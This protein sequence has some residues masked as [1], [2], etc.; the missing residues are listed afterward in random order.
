MQPLIKFYCLISLLLLITTIAF[1]KEPLPDLTPIIINAEQGLVEVKNLGNVAA[2]PS[3]L[4]V[5]CSTFLKVSKSSPCASG[6]HLSGYIKKWN[7]LPFN[8]P[9]LKPGASYQIHLFSADAF[10]RKIG[11]YGMKITADPLK[12]ITESNE[13]NNYTRL[14]TTIK[15][16]PGKLR[17]VVQDDSKHALKSFD[18][19]IQKHGSKKNYQGIVVSGNDKTSPLE[20]KI[21]EGRYDVHIVS[22][23]YFYAGFNGLNK[24]YSHVADIQA[25]MD[26]HILAP[27]REKIIS[28]TLIKSRKT[29]DKRV[30]FKRL[31]VGFLKINVNTDSKHESKFW[32][33]IKPSGQRH[34][35]IELYRPFY[36]DSTLKV[37]LAAG[38][39]L[40]QIEPQNGSYQGPGYKRND[41]R[42]TIKPGETLQ[43]K[44]TFTRQIKGK[45]KLTVLLN[46]N[47]SKAKI[48]ILKAGGKGRF[49]ATRAS[50][51]MITNRVELLPGHYD[52]SVVPLEY[53]L[54]LGGVDVFHGGVEGPSVKTKRIP[55][56]KP[57]IL[58]N[59]E[60]KPG[61]SLEKTLNFKKNK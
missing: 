26:Q 11:N 18:Y 45:L 58:H 13:S 8:V 40:V 4:Y 32:L 12:K 49:G 60:I 37:P 43:Q 51:N 50:F 59:I 52:I 22:K 23:N 3:Q 39:Y 34:S 47:K 2:K 36:F 38:S 6:L 24:Y 53:T 19:F 35:L 9:K 54:S 10:P 1:S 7:V 28:D 27:M 41:F 55:N 25:D 5:V 33:N 61:E 57:I 21:P 15:P 48:G 46:G 14:D 20:V 16:D 17:V 42:V 56:I 30:V 29:T 31:K 44:V